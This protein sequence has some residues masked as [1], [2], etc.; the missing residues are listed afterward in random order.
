[1]VRS[2]VP[3]I[4]SVLMKIKAKVI[5]DLTFK[6]R[7]A[8]LSTHENHQGQTSSIE[9]NPEQ[10]SSRL[11]SE[12][13]WANLEGLYDRSFIQVV[14]LKGELKKMET[15]LKQS[16]IALADALETLDKQSKTVEAYETRDRSVRLPIEASAW[17]YCKNCAKGWL[18]A[19]K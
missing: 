14:E 19:R 9:R 7:A 15:A 6:L 8:T 1:M 11:S 12:A 17:K 16:E 4:E 10:T 18:E 13:L 3:T 2:Y 5:Q